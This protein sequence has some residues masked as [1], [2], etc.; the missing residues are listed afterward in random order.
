VIGLLV[1]GD[2][3]FVTF[4][5]LPNRM[6]A[7]ELVQHWSLIQIGA[8]IPAHLKDWQITTKA[9]REEL[10]WAV[11]VPGE[12]APSAPVAQLLAELAAR[13]IRIHNSAADIW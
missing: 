4:G 5:P 2:N 13:G 10:Q 9:F 7:L 8:E 6:T 11:L 1:H 12:Q 3:H